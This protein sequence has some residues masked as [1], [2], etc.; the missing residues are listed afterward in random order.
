MPL[1]LTV[2]GKA[3]IV[4]HEAQ[5]FQHMI[6][7]LQSLEEELHKLKLEAL[8]SEIDIGIKQLESG[9]YT[10][11]NDESLSAFF[12]DIQARGQKNLL[13]SDSV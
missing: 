11:H 12:A 6:D 1:V 7:R 10:E 4:V 13:D 8:R 2:N 9:Q 3:E 5:A